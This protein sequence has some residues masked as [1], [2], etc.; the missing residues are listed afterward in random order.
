[1][2]SVIKKGKIRNTAFCNAKFQNKKEKRLFCEEIYD[3]IERKLF[4]TERQ[5]RNYD[6]IAEFRYK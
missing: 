4:Y 3:K 1:M 5:R 2:K 6:A